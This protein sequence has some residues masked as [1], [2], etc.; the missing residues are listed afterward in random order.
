MTGEAAQALQNAAEAIVYSQARLALALALRVP[1]ERSLRKAAALAQGAQEV[2]SL[3][4]GTR[5]RSAA[6]TTLI[7]QAESLVGRA[8]GPPVDDKRVAEALEEVRQELLELWGV[9]L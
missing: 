7:E 8:T 6:I 3:V 1:G 2:L 4:R 5:V 9:T